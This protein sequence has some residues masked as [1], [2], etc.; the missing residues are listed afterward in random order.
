MSAFDDALKLTLNFEGGRSNEKHDR[1]GL[2][3]F[4]VTQGSYTRWR[5]RNGQPSRPVTLIEPGEIRV[6]YH[7]D[8]WMAAH[9][10]ELPHDLALC[11]FDSAVN[12]GVQRAIKLLQTAV[13]VGADGRFGPVTRA[14]VARMDEQRVID[15]FLDAR[16][17]FYAD[18][19]EHDPT[20]A[21]FSR[22]WSNRVAALRMKLLD[23][24]K[25]IA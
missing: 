18:I 20:Q 21:K 10:D 11:V 24:D 8:Y 6:I 1:G 23:E 25:G 9:C 5:R 22:G 7:D 15:N 14:A 17:D 3:M 12:H 19:V 4:G 13:H 16:E 2:T